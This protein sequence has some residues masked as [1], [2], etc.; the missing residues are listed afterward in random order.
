VL[1][2]KR[3]SKHM[4]CAWH[5]QSLSHWCTSPILID[6]PKVT[7]GQLPAFLSAG[8][9]DHRTAC[10]AAACRLMSGLPRHCYSGT[11]IEMRASFL[12]TW[13]CVSL[14]CQVRLLL[15][16]TATAGVSVSAETC[17]LMYCIHW[18]CTAASIHSPMSD[19]GLTLINIHKLV[20]PVN[21]FLEKFLP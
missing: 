2:G 7:C 16:V 4:H 1:I 19:I 21:H 13:P 18:Y 10:W 11:W 3:D 20:S 12:S 8:W 5:T 6:L 14:A 15:I 17:K 9:S